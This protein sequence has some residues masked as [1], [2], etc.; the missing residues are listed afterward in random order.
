[1]R[2]ILLCLGGLTMLGGATLYAGQ[3]YRMARE[4]SPASVRGRAT[5]FESINRTPT[6]NPVRDLQVYLFTLEASKPFGTPAQVPP[7]HGAAKGRSRPNVSSV[8]SSFGRGVRVDPEVA[9]HGYGTD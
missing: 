2:K 4:A 1:M 6:T 9:G 3:A 8:R 5:V 7:S